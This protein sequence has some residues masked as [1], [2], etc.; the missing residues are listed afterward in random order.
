MKRGCC[1]ALA[2][3]LCALVVKGVAH[4]QLAKLL[5]MMEVFGVQGGATGHLCCGNDQRIPV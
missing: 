2:P 3:P 4:V 5:V 1:Q